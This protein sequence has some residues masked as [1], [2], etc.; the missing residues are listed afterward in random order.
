MDAVFRKLNY[1]GQNLIWVLNPPGSFKNVIL[2]VADEALIT[3]GKDFNG[4]AGFAIVFAILKKDLDE[5]VHLVVPKLED[6]AV[7]WICYPKSA[8]KNYKCDFNRDTGFE[9]LG[10]YQMEPVRQVAIDKDWSALRFRHVKYIKNL[11][12]REGMAL[13]EEGKRRAGK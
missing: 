7:F 12:R 4:K 1:K 10:S 8:S 2:S 5:L 13:S 6:D 3:E 11:S 9:L